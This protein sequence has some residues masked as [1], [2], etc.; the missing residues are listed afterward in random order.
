MHAKNKPFQKG[1][2]TATHR[3]FKQL[4][5][6]Q[7]LKPVKKALLRIY[8]ASLGH[9][10]VYSSVEGSI[11]QLATFLTVAENQYQDLLYTDAKL[12]LEIKKEGELGSVF[13]QMPVLENHEEAD[14]S[15]IQGILFDHV[16]EKFTITVTQQTPSFYGLTGK[17][18]KIVNVVV[19]PEG[20]VRL[21][22]EWFYKPVKAH[23][24]EDIKKYFKTYNHPL[25]DNMGN[26][27][28]AESVADCFSKWFEV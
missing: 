9:G 27:I 28:T 14:D 13:H 8:E 24:L 10:W 25:F 2:G 12:L 11:S 16:G 20:K 4:Q 22:S 3:P 23:K 19:L 17:I 21:V 7:P 6:P 26:K 15:Y 18:S 1:I 5:R